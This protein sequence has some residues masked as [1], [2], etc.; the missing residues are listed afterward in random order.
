MSIMTDPMTGKEYTQAQKALHRHLADTIG[1]DVERAMDGVGWAHTAMPPPVPPRPDTTATPGTPANPV[2][3][4]TPQSQLTP[5]TTGQPLDWE[6]FRDTNGLIL[7]K[8]KEPVQAV[9]GMHSLLHMAKD[10]LAQRDTAVLEADRFRQRLT[11]PSPVTV[12]APTPAPSRARSEKLD[13]VLSRI[14]DN[15]NVLD[16]EDLQEIVDATLEHS[17]QIAQ[18]AVEYDRN[19]RS[20][21]AQKWSEVDTYMTQNHPDSM[22]HVTEMQVFSATKPEVGR[23]Y[24]RILAAGDEVARLDA[25]LYLWNQ[26]VAAN[27]HLAQVPV[28]PAKAATEHALGVQA[29]VRKDEVDAA[30]RD[31][32]L[33]GNVAGGVHESAP[34]AIADS[35]AINRA[36]QMMKQLGE[37]GQGGALWRSLT[38]AKDLNHPIFDTYNP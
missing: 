4:A 32:G 26:Y 2:A 18:A 34:T 21:D 8:Y 10:A 6:Q 11:S 5:P 22:R 23:V 28:D 37:S 27:T 16:A 29:Q 31:A 38:I 33:L 13:T 9:Q 35:E 24:N 14:K 20:L 1:A 25:T 15:N 3:P 36:A 17:T 7:G 30:R 12:P 19:Q